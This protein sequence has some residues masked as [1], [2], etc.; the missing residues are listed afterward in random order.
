MQLK[1]LFFFLSL[2]SFFSCVQQPTIGLNTHQFNYFPGRVIY[3]FLPGLDFSQVEFGFVDDGVKNSKNT[4]NIF[5]KSVCIGQTINYNLTDLRPSPLSVLLM[6]LSG[7][8]NQDDSKCSAWEGSIFAGPYREFDG[9]E[10][11]RFFQS[12]V[13]SAYKGKKEF[14]V[15]WLESGVSDES[16]LIKSKKCEGEQWTKSIHYFLLNSNADTSQLKSYQMWIQNVKPPVGFYR[17]N[18]CDQKKCSNTKKEIFLKMLQKLASD[19]RFAIVWVDYDLLNAINRKD[20]K[21]VYQKLNEYQE[22]IDTAVNTLPSD[23]LTIVS[24]ASSMP[25]VYP[26]EGNAWKEMDQN[27]DPKKNWTWIKSHSS[28]GSPLFSFGAAAENFCGIYESSEVYYRMLRG[29][30]YGQ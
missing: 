4:N 27:K 11:N 10:K 20:W 16:S 18:S 2:I 24:A 14:P 30:E 1:F 8:I 26:A 3:F 12:S 7:K 21:E 17:E 6:Q 19:K 29:L 13:S 5:R 25:I 28:L 15:F 23:T 22:L 9:S